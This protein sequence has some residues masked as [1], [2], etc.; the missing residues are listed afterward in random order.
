VGELAIL[1]LRARV[2]RALGAAFD[3]RRFHDAILAGGSLPLAVLED[4]IARFIA[5]ELAAR[6]RGTTPAASAPRTAA[7]RR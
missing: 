5:A 7:P 1:D 4:E 6:K 3:I 2:E